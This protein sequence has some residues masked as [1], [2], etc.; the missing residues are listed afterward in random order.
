MIYTLKNNDISI[1]VNT[2]GAEMTSLMRLDSSYEYLWQGNPSYW[3]RQAPLLFPIVGA[4]SNNQYN[5]NNKTYTLEQHGFARDSEFKCVD[6]DGTE[7]VL[8]LVQSSETL[9]KY[10]FDF[11]LYIAYEL[12]GSSV[13]VSYR[14]VNMNSCPMPFSIGAHPAF[15]WDSEAYFLFDSETVQSYDIVP[16]GIVL[17]EEVLLPEKLPIDV[18]M[19]S[20]DALIYGNVDKADFINGDKKVSM[21]FK[22]FPFLGLWSKAAGAPF[23]CIEPWYGIGDLV[24][25]KGDIL[26]KLGIIDLEPESVFEAS[27][28]ISI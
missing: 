21:S 18:A 5:Y 7:I 25:H 15:N 13:E 9:V 2:F 28:T 6:T 17:G 8:K 10:P 27:Y 26:T 19:F 3:K 22:D 14:V 12:K 24:D 11:E 16:E 20:N 23:V 4:L 1:C